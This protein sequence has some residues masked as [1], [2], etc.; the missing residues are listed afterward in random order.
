FQT[1]TEMGNATFAAADPGKAPDFIRPFAGYLGPEA[2]LLLLMCEKN[3][4]AGA[5]QSLATLM[6]DVNAGASMVDDL[7]K[8]SGWAIAPQSVN[9]GDARLSQS[10]LPAAA[11]KPTPR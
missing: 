11:R 1:F 2:R 9:V 4:D 10:Q 5:A 6:S 3:G 7:N 8:R